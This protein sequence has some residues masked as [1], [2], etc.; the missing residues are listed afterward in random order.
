ME[1]SWNVSKDLVRSSLW[2]LKVLRRFWWWTNVTEM[3]TWEMWWFFGIE[4]SQTLSSWFREF[5]GGPED[6]FL[7]DDRETVFSQAQMCGGGWRGGIGWFKHYR[8]CFKMSHDT[9]DRE[10]DE[11]CWTLV[12]RTSQVYVVVPQSTVVISQVYNP[13]IGLIQ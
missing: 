11:G 6:Q 5:P 2:S 7:L 9:V 13:N 3:G 12:V 10:D 4:G 8:Y 1:N